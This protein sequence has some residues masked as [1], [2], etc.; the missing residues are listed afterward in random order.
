MHWQWGQQMFSLAML[1]GGHSI[2]SAAS[3][4]ERKAAQVV[5]GAAEKVALREGAKL[6]GA[7][8]EL[9]LTSD[10]ARSAKLL[11]KDAEI[12]K[13][14]NG[15]GLFLKENIGPYEPP[16]KVMGQSTEISCVAASCRMAANLDDIPEFYVRGAINTDHS[17]AWLSDMPNGLRDL[18]FKGSAEYLSGASIDRIAEAANG[19]SSVIVNVRTSGGGLHAIVVDSIDSGR[20]YIRDPWPLGTGSSY[21]VPVN[22]L[23]EVLGK[24]SKTGEKLGGIVIITPEVKK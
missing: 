24:A 21:S 13:A 1:W 8:L 6:G 17:G 19:S 9:A 15:E 20:A 12:A 4:A 14:G 7:P 5:A 23:R 2:G 10:A 11:E 22:D 18:G 16:S 3:F